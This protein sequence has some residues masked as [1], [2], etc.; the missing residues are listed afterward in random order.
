[1]LYFPAA[2]A[3]SGV[4]S[5]SSSNST[6]HV[7]IKEVCSFETSIVDTANRTATAARAAARAAAALQIP[8]TAATT[9]YANSS[10]RWCIFE[11]AAARNS[12][13]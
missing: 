9:A 11:S 12:H 2:G 8:T 5:S 7:K 6:D 10:R 1:M 3:Q 13:D 4:G